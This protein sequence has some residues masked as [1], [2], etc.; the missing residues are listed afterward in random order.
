TT[1]KFVL[2]AS[3]SFAASYAEKKTANGPERKTASSVSDAEFLDGESFQVFG[4]QVQLSKM[5]LWD[6]KAENL[7]VNW[8]NES[9]SKYDLYIQAFDGCSSEADR[10]A[11]RG[12]SGL[13]FEEVGQIAIS[14]EDGLAS[15]RVDA[16]DEG[17]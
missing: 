3:P 14:G 2:R 12:L 10:E 9:G 6:G 4:K 13:K 17:G 15:I 1:S 11:L 16:K 5:L 7:E 8:R